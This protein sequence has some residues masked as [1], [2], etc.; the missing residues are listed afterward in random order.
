[1]ISLRVPDELKG[2]TKQPCDIYF[3]FFN[4]PND[5]RQRPLIKNVAV[6]TTAL[7]KLVL[8]KIFK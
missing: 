4:L 6:Y 3:N 5:T 1:M 8:Y 2:C 7:V